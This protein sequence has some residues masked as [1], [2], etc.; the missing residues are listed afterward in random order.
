MAPATTQ[1]TRLALPVRNTQ[2]T[3]QTETGRWPAQCDWCDDPA[4]AH[5]VTFQAEQGQR[6]CA[7][8][9][10]QDAVAGAMD[11]RKPGN[12]RGASEPESRGG[13]GVQGVR[14][15]RGDE[16][17]TPALR[18]RVV[19]RPTRPFAVT[20]TSVV[21]YYQL[22]TRKAR[23]ADRQERTDGVFRPGSLRSRSGGC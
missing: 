23:S 14:D 21:S 20:I 22:T 13:Y 10:R 8:R 9:D 5:T 1:T 17:M 7:S 16:R 15:L 19:S 2:S 12:S 4:H 6:Q 3:H 18:G 11:E